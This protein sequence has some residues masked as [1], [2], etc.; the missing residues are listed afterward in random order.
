MIFTYFM[1]QIC[2]LSCYLNIDTLL[3]IAYG[4]LLFRAIFE[5]VNPKENF[6]S[7]VFMLKICINGCVCLYLSYDDFH[8]AFRVSL[9]P[10]SFFETDTSECRMHDLLYEGPRLNFFYPAT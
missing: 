3:N 1:Q 10:I 2:L 7:D 9:L 6:N 8:K 4:G 5:S